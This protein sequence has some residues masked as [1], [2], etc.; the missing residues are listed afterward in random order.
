MDLVF[1]N[2]WAAVLLVLL[3]LV[4]WRT[5]HVRAWQ[6]LLRTAMLAAIVIALAAPVLLERTAP[7]PQVLVLDQRA[8]LSAE[9]RQAARDAVAR[10]VAQAPARAAV[11][12]LQLGGRA[13]PVSGA[14]DYRVLAS[15]SPAAALEA[16]LEMLPAQGGGRVRYVGSARSV[17]GHWGRAVSA[18]ASRGIEVVAEPMPTAAGAARVADV[19]LQP[20]RAGGRA[21]ARIALDGEGTDLQVVLFRDATE[22]A[23]SPVLAV[24]GPQEVALSF[25]AGPAGFH[26]LRAELQP[27]AGG[28]ALSW[29]AATEAVQDP[30]SLL[31]IGTDPA[32]GAHL[33]RLLGE[34]FKV[35]QQAPA[36][37]APEA[38]QGRSLT[39]I[40]GVGLDALAAPVQAAVA[41]AVSQH[42]MGLVFSGGSGAFASLP[43]DPDTGGALARL[44]PVRG[45]PQEQLQ[46]PSV[47]LVVIIDTSGSMAGAP[48]DLAKQ[49]ARLAV[50][51][52]KPEDRVGVVEFYGARQWSVPIQPARDT[53]EVERAIGRMQAQG[54]TQLF[55]AIQEAYFGLK[56]TDARFKHM[57]VITDAGVEEDNYQRLL[58]HI[59]Q[60]RINVSTALVGGGEGEQRMADLANWG[61]GRFYQVGEE[62]SMVELNF[63]QQQLQPRP[64]YRPGQYALQARPG[65]RWWQPADF[66]GMPTLQGLATAVPREG[67]EV[68]AAAGEA[69]VVVGWQHGAG[70]VT[71]L[72]T[73]PLG[74]GTRSWQG[75]PGYGAWLARLLAG[76]ARAQAPLAMQAVR[77]G[78]AL[79]VTVQRAVS[80]GGPTPTL[81]LLDGQGVAV[82][83]PLQ[84]RAPDLW[85]ASVELPQAQDAR[86]ALSDGADTW[87][88]ADRA[89]SDAAPSL[90]QARFTLPLQALAARAPAADAGAG[91]EAR[92]LRGAFALLAIALY[93]L[94]LLCRR[95]PWAPLGFF[96]I[97]R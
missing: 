36:N 91:W 84:A 6:R 41:D 12:V 72:L 57:L 79:Q 59:A 16:A 38:V 52:L 67:A 40:D 7:P 90:Q 28:A 78:G 62:S 37:L 76:T 61:R 63:K 53:A 89:W 43:R 31:Y 97:S 25:A 10:H 8:L 87:R 58:R 14:S 77:E 3:S 34:G 19:A 47:A 42:G 94:E 27:A 29:L 93:L 80:A 83:V 68:A 32:A 66:A 35:Q 95:W 85:Q 55:P 49:I 88:L 33:Q 11:T 81:S 64:A 51:R 54:G 21:Q 75:W 56:N 44:L 1:Q 26:P 5:A 48:M 86:L 70:R 18:L 60:D 4:W 9:Q 92:D 46:D 39:V 82:A 2:P 45:E 17:D 23:R 74:A 50:R 69:P 13:M 15:G 20:V 73:E 96:R 30:L 22:V 71:T 24:R 65:Q